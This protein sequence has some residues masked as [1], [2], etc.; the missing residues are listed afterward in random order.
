MEHSI[1]IGY[2]CGVNR[3]GCFGGGVSV[4]GVGVLTVREV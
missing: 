1:S 4:G 3:G 2:G